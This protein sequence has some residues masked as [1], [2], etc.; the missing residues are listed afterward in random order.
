M[1]GFQE[2]FFVDEVIQLLFL[3]GGYSGIVVEGYRGGRKGP[4]RRLE[5]INQLVFI[6]GGSAERRFKT[7]QLL[8][9]IRL[10]LIIMHNLFQC[11][12]CIMISMNIYLEDFKSKTQSM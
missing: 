2:C 11:R 8:V 12:L 3:M 7:D 6:L 10:T 1:T 9:Q 4:L 5:V